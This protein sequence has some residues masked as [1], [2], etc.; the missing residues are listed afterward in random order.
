MP[1]YIVCYVYQG[2]IVW[3]WGT[4]SYTSP[5]HAQRIADDFNKRGGNAFFV[6]LKSAYIAYTRERGMRYD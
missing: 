1:R 6:M 2:D 3:D 4:Q 5:T